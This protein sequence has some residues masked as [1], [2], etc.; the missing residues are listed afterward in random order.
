[1]VQSAQATER[2]VGK[3][4]KS[5]RVR[6]VSTGNEELDLKLPGGLPYPSL[7]IIEGD[8]GTGKSVLVQQFVFGMLRE[9]F[10]VVVFTT[11]TSIRDYI[12]KMES[13]S[14]K[15]V[16]YFL[17]GQLKVYSTQM[18]GV[19][20]SKINAKELLPVIGEW[21]VENSSSF[22]ALAVDSLSHLA[23]YA[24]PTKVLDFFNKIRLLT[25]MGKVV[26]IT[27]HEGVLREDLATRARAMCDGY[28]KLR[29]AS[30]GG[31]TVKVM[32]VVKLN[33]AP[34]TFDTTIS[35]DVDPAFGIKIV[36]IA[37]ARA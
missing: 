8:H 21:V 6:V 37:L 22:D 11:E 28:I 9:G 17:K 25:D 29:V 7:I 23:I 33:G 5:E 12:S 1:M 15:V 16:W 2:K 4:G 10:K 24:T 31:R 14:L 35:F 32:E 27:L 20:W 13:I 36:P 30:I 34:R 18:P 3:K 19:S 26:L